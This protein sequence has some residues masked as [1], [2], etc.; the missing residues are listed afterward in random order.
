MK[1]QTFRPKACIS[2][3][4]IQPPPPQFDNS[5]VLH[6]KEKVSAIVNKETKDKVKEL[7]RNSNRSKGNGQYKFQ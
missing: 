4:S 5:E 1:P 6:Y 3:L 2:R 7:E